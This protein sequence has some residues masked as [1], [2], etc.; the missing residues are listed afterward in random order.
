MKSCPTHCCPIHGCK[1]ADS[2]CPVADGRCAPVYPANNGCEACDA[3]PPLF[4]GRCNEQP[5]NA[6]RASI[7]IDP[8]V[9]DRLSRL[10]YMPQMHGVGYSAF[11]NRA[12]HLAERDILRGKTL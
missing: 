11:L 1:Y 10:L 2:E 3:L 6:E 9:R 8:A 4:V 7:N 5:M 12:C